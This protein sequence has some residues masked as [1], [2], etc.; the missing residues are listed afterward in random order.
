MKSQ[1]KQTDVAERLGKQEKI[2]TNRDAVDF[3]MEKLE[4]GAA[5]HAVGWLP[6]ADHSAAP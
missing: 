4:K 2:I 6:L 5:H 1:V 3:R